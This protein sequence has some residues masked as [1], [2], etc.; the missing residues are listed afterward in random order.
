MAVTTVKI[1]DFLKALGL[2]ELNLSTNSIGIALSNTAPASEAVD[3]TTSGNG[4]LANVTEISY[5]NYA[6]DMITDRQL[7]GVTWV[8]SG[9]RV[10]LDANDLTISASGGDLAPWRYIYVYDKTATTPAN[11]LIALIDNGAS[12]TLLNGQSS[13]ITWDVNGIIYIQ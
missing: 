13:P 1:P 5:T 9:G 8:E 11:P 7:E 3:P 4:V 12:I 10:T 2:A 6:D